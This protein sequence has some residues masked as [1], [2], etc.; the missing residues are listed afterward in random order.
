MYRGTRGPAAMLAL[1]VTAGLTL[2]L[3]AGVY[4]L[5]RPAG[6]AWLIPSAWQA[7]TP[8][9]WFG[10]VGLWLPSF[11]H[12]FAFS[13]L[14][15][16]LLPRRLGFAAAGC[17]TW[18]LIDTLAECGQHAA[19]SVPLASALEAL[20]GNSAVAMQV[21]RYFTQ[22][23]FAAADVAAG[24]AGSAVAFAALWLAMPRRQGAVAA[25]APRDGLRAPA[26]VLCSFL[27]LE[28]SSTTRGSST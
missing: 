4:L 11:A 18:A 20:L 2:A 15:A 10:R 7:Q 17:L 22:G 14:T 6:S 21:G 25:A 5:D 3:G 1:A 28:R 26:R 19:A 23:S 16:L 13:V 24:L 8:G 9:P 12:A 27:H